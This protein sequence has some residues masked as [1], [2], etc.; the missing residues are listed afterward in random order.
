LGLSADRLL[1]DLR[2]FGF[3]FESLAVRDLRVYAGIEGGRLYHYRDSAGLEADAILEYPDGSWA[4]VEVKLGM[5]AV[6]EAAA[7]LLA[8]AAKVNTGMAGE[9]RAL[10]VITGDGFAHRRKDGVYVVPLQTLRP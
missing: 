6:D 3:V 4:A 9:P 2:Y 8:L 7:H 10:V 5:A 1:V